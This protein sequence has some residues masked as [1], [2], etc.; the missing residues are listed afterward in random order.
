M[1]GRDARCRKSARDPLHDRR[2]APRRL[3]PTRS[4]A[5]EY[6]SGACFFALE[7]DMGTEQIKE[8]DLKGSTIVRKLR[9]YRTILRDQV[10]RQRNSRFPLC[11]CSS[12]P[13]AWCACAT[14]WIA[15]AAWL[16]ADGG[17]PTHGFLFKAVPE[18]ARRTRDKPAVSGHMLAIPGIG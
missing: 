6:P 4:S 1:P 12:S 17:G 11:R 7:T 18:L 13:R 16:E 5:L 10:Y 15:C 8:H 2:R 14:S 9:G 3:F